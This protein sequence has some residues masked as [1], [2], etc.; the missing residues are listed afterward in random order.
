L[1]TQ[2]RLTVSVPEA[3]QML[4]ISERHG[5]DMVREGQLPAL[6]LGNRIVVP[7]QQLQKMLEGQPVGAAPA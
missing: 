7:V 6:R 3:A 2:E 1:E 5:Y 4:G